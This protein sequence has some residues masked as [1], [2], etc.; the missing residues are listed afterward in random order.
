[1]ADRQLYLGLETLAHRER[2]ATIAIW[3]VMTIAGLMIVGQ[4]LELAGVLDLEAAELSPIATLVGLI[5]LLSAVAYLVSV[6]LVSMWIHRA[7]ANLFDAGL[8]GLEYTPGW[9]VGWFFV[10]IA[11]LFKPFQAM[12]ELWNASHGES[13]NYTAPAASELSMWW[14]AF[15]VG[16]IADN[17]STR[18]SLQAGPEAMPVALTLGI[19]GSALTIVSAWCLMRIIQ[20]VGTA[21]RDYLTFSGTFD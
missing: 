18:L 14:G 5:Y 12:R 1:M 21:Q 11:N 9:S 8:V 7:H 10:P 6:V 16:N 17:I 4:L 19:I 13:D 2:W 15:I 20:Q 3:A